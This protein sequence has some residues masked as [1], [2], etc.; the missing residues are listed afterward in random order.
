MTDTPAMPFRASPNRDHPA[1]LLIEGFNDADF[2][3]DDFKLA[4]ISFLAVTLD[5]K[6]YQDPDVHAEDAAA[7]VALM[8]AVRDFQARLTLSMDR[9]AA[10]VA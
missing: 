5:A 4:L 7:V 1:S 10:G 6:N 2:A 9:V 3:A 8:K